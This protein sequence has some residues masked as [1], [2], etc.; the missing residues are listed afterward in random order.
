MHVTIVY[1]SINRGMM[2]ACDS[3]VT[4]WCWSFQ[5]ITINWPLYKFWINIFYDVSSFLFST[6]WKEKKKGDVYTSLGT[7][8]NDGTLILLGNVRSDKTFTSRYRS[9]AFK[10]RS[11]CPHYFRVESIDLAVMKKYL[12]VLAQLGGLLRSPLHI[13]VLLL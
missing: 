8:I 7:I 2:L 12:L 4:C 13:L 9:M 3:F 6:F 5:S 10:L 11:K 1:T